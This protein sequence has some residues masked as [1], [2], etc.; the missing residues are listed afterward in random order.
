MP[1]EAVDT[2]GLADFKKQLDK[3][4]E[5]KNPASAAQQE[6]QGLGLGDWERLWEEV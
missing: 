2:K 6:S 5:D 4:V 1:Q 3:A